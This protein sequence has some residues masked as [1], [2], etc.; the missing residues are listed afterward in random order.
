MN[1][2]FKKIEERNKL[3]PDKNNYYA[4]HPNSENRLE[5][6]NSLSQFK[7]D[8][9]N[10]TVYYKNLELDLQKLKIKLLAY[11]KNKQKLNLIKKT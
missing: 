3:F 6:I 5:I 8:N 4:S 2:F 9:L 7:G 1:K 11:T 10:T